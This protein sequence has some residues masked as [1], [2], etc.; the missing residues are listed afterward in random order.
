M[1]GSKDGHKM[2]DSLKTLKKKH[3]ELSKKIEIMEEVRDYDRS[4]VT[5]QRLVDLKKQ[6]LRLKDQIAELENET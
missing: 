4:M 5:K 3:K 1:Q 6:K 2:N